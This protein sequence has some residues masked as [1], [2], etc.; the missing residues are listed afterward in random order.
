MADPS[1]AAAFSSVAGNTRASDSTGK[2]VSA[3]HSTVLIRSVMFRHLDATDLVAIEE[4]G[5]SGEEAERQIMLLASPPPPARLV[6]PCILGDGIHQT[7]ANEEQDAAATF[8]RVREADR[9]LSF[10]PASGAAS[11]MFQSLAAARILA[12][13]SN[14]ALEQAAKAG[15]ADAGDCLSTLARIR[16]LAI[17]EELAVLFGERGL[18]LDECLRSGRS[19]E[20]LAA[21]LDDRGLNAGER[22]KGLLPFHCTESGP[23]SAFTEHLFEACASIADGSGRVRLHFTIAAAHRLAFEAELARARAAIEP[24]LKVSLEVSFSTQSPSTDTLA[25]ADNGALFRD[26]DQNILFRPGGH[27]SLLGNLEATGGDLV[28][29]KNIDNVA[30]D[31]LRPQVVASRQRLS[32]LA[33]WLSEQ[34]HSLTRRLEALNDDEAPAAARDWLN[35]WAA[36]P[37]A[38][39]G[40]ASAAETRLVLLDALHRPLRVCGM[41]R[42]TGDPGGGPFWVRD[43]SG[44]IRPQIVETAQID[45]DS[46]EQQAILRQSTHFNPSDMVC[47]LRD[48]H[49]QPHALRDFIDPLTAFVT[50][51]SNAGRGLRAL[52]HPGLWN[53]SMAGWLNI[54]VEIPREV[55]LPVKTLAD[56]LTDAHRSWAGT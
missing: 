20:I 25:L 52:E 11:R 43:A 53:G 19:A 34:V 22:P 27:G 28:L 5:L 31:R 17:G 41:V 6:R 47:A 29:I 38:A 14:A 26:P 16:E 24:I 21:L 46:D 56:L 13:D 35:R 9:L 18:D 42:N 40:S 51:K 45:P 54:F 32:G 10:V 8:L 55:F 23:R 3:Q 4:H 39:T 12:G 48:H 33:A 7:T 37:A 2:R 36:V 1:E 30:P 49:G 44:S 50:T 15:N